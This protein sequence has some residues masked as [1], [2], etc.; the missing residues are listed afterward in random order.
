MPLEWTR[1]FS[2]SSAEIHPASP[3]LAGAS[4]ECQGTGVRA[5]QACSDPSPGRSSSRCNLRLMDFLT[6]ASYLS[7]KSPQWIYFYFLPGIS[8]IARIAQAL[9]NC[10]LSKAATHFQVEVPSMPAVT[11]GVL[12][13]LGAAR[14]NMWEQRSETDPPTL[15]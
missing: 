11:G 3:S 7:F 1:C 6:S 2:S 10:S 9:F 13:M 4:S 12:V 15:L 8:L 5:G 14:G